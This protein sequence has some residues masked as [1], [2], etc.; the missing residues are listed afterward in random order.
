MSAYRLGSAERRA[1]LLGQR[2]ELFAEP[3]S[4]CPP[5]V[6]S[7]LTGLRRRLETAEDDPLDHV[8]EG[9]RLYGMALEAGRAAGQ[10]RGLRRRH[11][12]AVVVSTFGSMLALIAG[13]VTYQY[14]EHD[15]LVNPCVNWDYDGRRH[16]VVRHDGMLGIEYVCV[17]ESDDDCAEPCA[18]EGAC[19]AEAGQCVPRSHAHCR[20]SEICRYHGECIRLGSRCVAGSDADCRSSEGCRLDGTCSFHGDRCRP[21]SDGDCKASVRCREEGLCRLGF[22]GCEQEHA[23]FA[24]EC[25]RM[26]DCVRTGLCTPADLPEGCPAG[27]PPAHAAGTGHPTDT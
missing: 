2:L 25:T 6:R 27:A 22:G 4:S 11:F 23:P 24:D 15:Q 13:R 5:D 7:E 16:E 3:L 18:R 8:E 26:A 17:A 14:V 21:R 20:Q 10:Q 12:Y 9:L 19:A 1:E